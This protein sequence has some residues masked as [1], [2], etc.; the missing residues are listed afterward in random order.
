MDRLLCQRQACER[1][2][3]CG[4]T[5]FRLDFATP[6]RVIQ[7]EASTSNQVCHTKQKPLKLVRAGVKTQ[8]KT[9]R[10]RDPVP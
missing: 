5:R 1:S 2:Q 3:I 6:E 4:S 8:Q 9:V 10:Q 7:L